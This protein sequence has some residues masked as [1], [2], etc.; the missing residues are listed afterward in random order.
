M[1]DNIE[2]GAIVAWQEARLAPSFPIELDQSFAMLL[3][4]EGPAV[5]PRRAGIVRMPAQPVSPVGERSPA[6]A[7]GLSGVVSNDASSG[8][9]VRIALPDAAQAKLDLF[10]LSGRKM[11]SRDVG[12]LGPGDHDMILGDGA[13]FPP[14][15]YLVRLRQGAHVSVARVAIVR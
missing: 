4:P 11:W 15:I 2:G 9:L 12:A 13:A 7:F 8:T 5:S 10:D 3:T 6:R 14:G 1:P